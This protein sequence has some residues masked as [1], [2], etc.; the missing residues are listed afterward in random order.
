LK[1]NQHI[2]LI[3]VQDNRLNFNPLFNLSGVLMD[4]DLFEKKK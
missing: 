4:K 1:P 3:L 2:P